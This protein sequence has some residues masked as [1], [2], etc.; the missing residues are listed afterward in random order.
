MRR[1]LVGV[2]LISDSID[3]RAPSAVRVSMIGFDEGSE[4]ERSLDGRSVGAI[5]ADLSDAV[6]VTQAVPLPENKDICFL[7]MMKAGPFEIDSATALVMLS[8]PTNVNG[9]SSE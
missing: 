4:Q 1:A 6:D 2:S 7:G 5:N 3:A 8:A 9:R